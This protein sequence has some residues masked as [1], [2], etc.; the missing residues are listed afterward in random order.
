[1]A[2][3]TADRPAS[4]PPQNRI[5]PMKQA[6][7]Q[8]VSSF[9]VERFHR[10]LRYHWLIC[11]DGKPDEL[12]AWGHASTHE[13]AQTAAQKMIG[14]LACGTSAGGPMRRARISHR[15]IGRASCRERV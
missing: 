10:N 12:V 13:L 3:P 5:A 2:L 4:R 7:V 8:Y 11:R 14:D 15:Q 1:M 9:Q 6:D